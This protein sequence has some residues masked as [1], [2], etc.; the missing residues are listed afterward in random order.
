[1]ASQ[2]IGIKHLRQKLYSFCTNSFRK[3]M[4]RASF[5]THLMRPIFNAKPEDIKTFQKKKT[6]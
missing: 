4:R 3:L 5:L 6:T 1:M 2:V